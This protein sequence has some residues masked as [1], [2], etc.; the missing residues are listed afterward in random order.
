C[1]VKSVSLPVNIWSSVDP[2]EA[3]QH[4]QCRLQPRVLLVGRRFG[5]RTALDEAG[6]DDLPI[7]QLSTQFGND[8]LEWDC[9][10]S[11]V[12]D[13]HCVDVA[14]VAGTASFPPTR[15][16]PS[17]ALA[18]TKASAKILL[19]LIRPLLSRSRL[20]ASASAATC[21]LEW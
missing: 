8:V 20:I 16:W 5:E 14:G 18:S 13:A 3:D 10:A 15:Q 6:V 19:L 1:V 17:V 9:H 2:R 7:S 21:S 4:V 11:L 12:G